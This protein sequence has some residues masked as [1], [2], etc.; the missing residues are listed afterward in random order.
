MTEAEQFDL[1]RARMLR[2]GAR[3]QCDRMRG[4]LFGVRDDLKEIIPQLVTIASGPT[5][6]M[7]EHLL[8]KHFPT[9]PP[10]VDTTDRV[11]S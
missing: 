4:R 10:M 11:G 2:D 8:D 7:L 6:L 9:S 3:K 5:R 1:E